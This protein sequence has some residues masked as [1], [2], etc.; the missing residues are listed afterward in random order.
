MQSVFQTIRKVADYRTTVLLTGESGTGKELVAKALHFNGLRKKHPFIAVNCGAIPEALLE[1][2]LFGHV[3][4]AFTDAVEQKQ[5]LF[6]AAN[7]GTLFLDEIGEL[8]VSLQVK[9]LRVLQ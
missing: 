3:R 6:E 8:P 9:L 7:E 4:G 5:G 2:E 1:S